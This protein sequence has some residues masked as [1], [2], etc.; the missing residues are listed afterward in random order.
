M[1]IGSKIEYAGLIKRDSG[2]L[3]LWNPRNFILRIGDTQKAELSIL[4]SEKIVEEVLTVSQLKLTKKCT[5]I[6]NLPCFGV[7]LEN[8]KKYLLAVRNIHDCQRFHA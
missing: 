7:V 3:S 8:G 6:E 1:Y 4:K 2:L 5:V